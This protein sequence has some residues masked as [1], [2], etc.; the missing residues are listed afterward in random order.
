MAELNIYPN[1]QVKATSTNL[2]GASTQLIAAPTG[3][4]RIVIR[5]LIVSWPASVT[6]INPMKFLSGATEI[7]PHIH[8][9]SPDVFDSKSHFDLMCAPAQAFNVMVTGTGSGTIQYYIDYELRG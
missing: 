9:L 5:R 1:F 7:G 6:A 3:I 8:A 4:Q 2:A